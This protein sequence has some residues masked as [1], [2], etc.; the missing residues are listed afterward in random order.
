[1]S[2][3]RI[4]VATLTVGTQLTWHPRRVGGTDRPRAKRPLRQ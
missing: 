2:T 1:M 3:C 4:G